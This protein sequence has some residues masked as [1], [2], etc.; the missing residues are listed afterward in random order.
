MEYLISLFI[1]KAASRVLVIVFIAL[2]L[3]EKHDHGNM[4]NGHVTQSRLCVL[5]LKP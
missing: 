5:L 4:P 1:L 2:M 3:N